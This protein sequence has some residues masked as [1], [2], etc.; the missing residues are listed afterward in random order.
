MKIGLELPRES[1]EEAHLHE[2][3]DFMAAHRQLI[4]SPVVFVQAWLEGKVKL[5]SA[6]EQGALKGLAGV[7][8][9]QDPF[10]GSHR[11]WGS[12]TIGEYTAEMLAAI[13][14]AMWIY[15]DRRD[16]AVLRSLAEH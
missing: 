12:F 2:L 11:W 6:R 1:D 5:F 3:L 10:D 9:V 13:D 4:Y 16:D 15:T 8:L 7:C 14:E